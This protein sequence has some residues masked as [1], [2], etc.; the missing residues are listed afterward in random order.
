MILNYTPGSINRVDAF[1]LE[2]CVQSHFGQDFS[3]QADEDGAPNDS[4]HEFTVTGDLDEFERDE[5]ED[6]LAKGQ[7]QAKN[8]YQTSN[9]LNLLCEQGHIPAGDY[10]VSLAY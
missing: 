3:F 4:V 9:L 1:A 6:F 8:L 10:L 5:V 7:C 2:D